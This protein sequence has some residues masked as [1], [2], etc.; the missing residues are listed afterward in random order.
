M[1]PINNEADTEK[2]KAIKKSY[3]K[4]EGGL[5]VIPQEGQRGGRR[6]V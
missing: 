4:K 3:G 6:D 5:C 1:F 2:G